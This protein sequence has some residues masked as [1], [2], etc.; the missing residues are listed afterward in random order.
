LLFF[1][2]VQIV[3]YKAGQKAALNNTTVYYNSA[4]YTPPVNLTMTPGTI[5]NL[6]TINPGFTTENKVVT[7]SDVVNDGYEQLTFIISEIQVKIN[8]LIN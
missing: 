3:V 8:L 5:M 2:T 6:T 4:T 1:S 7:V